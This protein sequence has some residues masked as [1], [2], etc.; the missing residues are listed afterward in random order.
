MRRLRVGS[1]QA[2]PTTAE[3]GADRSGTGSQQGEPRK[4]LWNAEKPRLPGL[5]RERGT[6]ESN[7]ALWFWRPAWEGVSAK[8]RGPGIL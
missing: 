7:L 1:I 8:K 2:A 3:F 4:W 5:S 6:E